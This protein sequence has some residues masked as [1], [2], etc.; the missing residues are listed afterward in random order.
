[1][2]TPVAVKVDDWHTQFK[3][4]PPDAGGAAQLQYVSQPSTKVKAEGKQ[5]WVGPLQFTISGYTD[6]STIDVPE[7][8][9][10]TAPGSIPAG[11][12]KVKAES[13]PVMLKGDKVQVTVKGQKT[14]SSGP[15]PASLAVT[16]EIIDAGQTKVNAT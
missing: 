2:G 1:M 10:T 11:A 7:S 4:T 6:G 14:T 8:G 15:V 3:L 12:K 9:A 5:V 13:K 16:V